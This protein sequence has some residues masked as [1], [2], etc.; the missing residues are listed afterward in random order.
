MEKKVSYLEGCGPWFSVTTEAI[1]LLSSK[2]ILFLKLSILLSLTTLTPSLDLSYI[3][4][5]SGRKI[6]HYL[7]NYNSKLK[8]VLGM[9]WKETKEVGK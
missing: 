9:M 7:G 2:T 5:T 3:A 1:N 6:K 8:M 4:P